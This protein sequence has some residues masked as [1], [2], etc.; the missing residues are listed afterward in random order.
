MKCTDNCRAMTKV[1][2]PTPHLITPSTN[3]PARVLF[4]PARTLSVQISDI[5]V[6]FVQLFCQI[7]EIILTNFLRGCGLNR[8]FL[9]ARAESSYNT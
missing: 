9:A 5:F 6:Y 7:V 4:G 2:S 3:P 8:I 1:P